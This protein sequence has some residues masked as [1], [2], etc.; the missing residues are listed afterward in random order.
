MEEASK[1][2]GKKERMIYQP[3]KLNRRDPFRK[4]ECKHQGTS[5]SSA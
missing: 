4:E 3:E 2:D 5:E 1:K